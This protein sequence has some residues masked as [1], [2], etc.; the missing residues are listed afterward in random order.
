VGRAMRWVSLASR[1]M[2][3]EVAGEASGSDA[4]NFYAGAANTARTIRPL[5]GQPRFSVGHEWNDL[6][7][8]FQQHLDVEVLP[9]ECGTIESTDL[10]DYSPD[11]VV[12]M[13]SPIPAAAIE[14][15]GFGH[16]Q[17]FGVGTEAIDVS[18]A[19]RVGVWVASM[20]GLSALSVVEHMPPFCW[21]PTGRPRGGGGVGDRF[22]R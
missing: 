5:I 7:Q 16:I 19:T 8:Y 22:C 11:I 21:R 2:D 6:A 15:G 4:I 14:H 9:V 3:V 17:Q 12:P 1:D 18:A 13:M 10:D 20:R